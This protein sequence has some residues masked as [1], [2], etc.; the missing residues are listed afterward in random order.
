MMPCSIGRVGGNA[1]A[2]FWR[3]KPSSSR[4]SVTAGISSGGVGRSRSTVP[5]PAR[6]GTAELPTCSATAPGRLA[7]ISS[8]TCLATAGAAA[9]DSRTMMGTRQ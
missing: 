1:V 4:S 8:A 7:A 2:T 9:L 5:L 6:P 3:W